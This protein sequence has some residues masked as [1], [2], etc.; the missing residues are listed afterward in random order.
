[1]FILL[2]RIDILFILISIPF[3]TTQK[4]LFLL[5]FYTERLIHNMTI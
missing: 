2:E 3:T 5:N 1:M 4:Q